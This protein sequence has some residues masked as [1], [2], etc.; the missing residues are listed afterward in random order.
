MKKPKPK[1][2]PSKEAIEIWR[3]VCDL[4]DALEE[5]VCDLDGDRRFVR[6]IQS[7]LDKFAARQEVTK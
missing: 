6:I 5:S 4:A 2:E 3:E 7:G 1:K